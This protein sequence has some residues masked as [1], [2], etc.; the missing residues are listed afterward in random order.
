MANLAFS[1]EKASQSEVR[2]ALMA[3]LADSWP[4][5][6]TVDFHSDG[7]GSILRAIVECEDTD[8]HLDKEFTDKLP[9][10]FMGWR[11]VILKVPIGHVRVFYSS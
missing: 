2:K 4:N 5:A 10:K 9:L 6:F 8:E 3:I 7:G 11:L 1:G